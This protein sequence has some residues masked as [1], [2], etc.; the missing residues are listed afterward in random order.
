MVMVNVHTYLSKK[1]VH[2]VVVSV[3]KFF[4]YVLVP[5]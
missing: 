3:V 5:L 4:I 1:F 2:L